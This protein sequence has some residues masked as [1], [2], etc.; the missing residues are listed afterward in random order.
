M[1]DTEVRVGPARMHLTSLV[2]VQCLQVKE[3]HRHQGQEPPW[4]MGVAGGWPQCQETM[5]VGW[6]AAEPL[7]A[8]PHTL[9]AG[10]N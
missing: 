10:V 6:Q 7:Y 2:C 9:A 1:S 3:G 4:G 5:G 8:Q